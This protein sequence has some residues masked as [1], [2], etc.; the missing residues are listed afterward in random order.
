[1]K[2]FIY[3]LFLSCLF[4]LQSCFEIVEQVSLRKDGSGSFQLVLNA[5]KSKTKLYSLEKMKVVNGRKIPSRNEINNK[6]GELEKTMLKTPGITNIKTTIDY[7]NY[8]ISLSC[9]FNKISQLNE[10]VKNIYLK[11]EPKG[12]VP[13]TIYQY[14]VANRTFNRFNTFSFKNEYKKLSNA[15][16]EIF[17]TANFTSIYKFENTIISSTNKSSKI[18]ASKKA[19]M[20]SLNALDIATEKKL[21]DNKIILNP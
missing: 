3:L 6:L 13:T 14:N 18:A 21:I 15:D 12:K 17:A 16:K 20:L 19:L 10:A 2:K 5:S 1:M 4:L 11:E 7:D 8:I 9:N